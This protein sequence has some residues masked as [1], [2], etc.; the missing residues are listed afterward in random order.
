MKTEEAEHSY[1][2]LIKDCGFKYYYAFDFVI[3]QNSLPGEECEKRAVVVTAILWHHLE[4]N[5]IN[6]QS[7]VHTVGVFSYW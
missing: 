6:N 3:N 4:H 1:D 2:I 5:F 7:L